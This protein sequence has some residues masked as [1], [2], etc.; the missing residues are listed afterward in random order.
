MLGS[1]YDRSKVNRQIRKSKKMDLWKSLVRD[2]VPRCCAICG[3]SRRLEVD[4]IVP[5]CTLLEQYDI[6]CE[7]EALDRK[8]LWDVKNG[9]LLCRVC[10]TRRTEGQRLLGVFSSSGVRR[11]IKKRVRMKLPERPPA[12]EKDFR[13]SRCCRE[14][15]LWSDVV[16]EPGCPWCGGWRPYSPVV[17]PR[18]THQDAL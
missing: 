9:R 14:Y 3:V 5:L 18:R 1:R 8:E 6:Y 15:T 11:K 13:C 10:H 4:H 2:S 12:Y 17:M 16:N 7:E